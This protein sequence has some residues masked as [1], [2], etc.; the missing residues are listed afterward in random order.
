[1]NQLK[2]LW[3][4]KITHE[5]FDHSEPKG[6]SL[7]FKPDSSILV[8][9]RGLMWRKVKAGEWNLIAFD[10]QNPFME[11]DK[12]VLELSVSGRS[13]VYVTDWDWKLSRECYE[14][15]LSK[16]Q[17]NIDMRGVIGVKNTA[18]P[19]VFFRLNVEIEKLIDAQPLVTEL[20]FKTFD[21]Y[22]EYIFIPRD[23]NTD[24]ELKLEDIKGLVTFNECEQSIFLESRCL[25]CCSVEKVRMKENFDSS[26]R[27]WE[28]FPTGK[29]VLANQIP[30]PEPGR[31]INA[32]DDT[33]L[34]VF[35]F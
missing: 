4:F 2:I 19:K 5:Y 23:K 30:C 29:K 20:N 16:N 24:R 11:D 32:A 6:I 28:L 10:D 13:L 3:V 21:K 12:I 22:W 14:L 15:N 17:L 33:L 26:L 34:H 18:S 25:R 27:L 8:L 9:R 31:F 1:M 7:D 35:Y